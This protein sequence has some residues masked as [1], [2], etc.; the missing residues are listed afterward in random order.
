MSKNTPN[1]IPIIYKNYTENFHQCKLSSNPCAANRM[2]IESFN[3]ITKLHLGAV[4][5][6]TSVENY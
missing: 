6:F 4:L 3:G 5:P 2:E 1:E